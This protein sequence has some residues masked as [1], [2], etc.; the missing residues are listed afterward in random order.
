MRGTRATPP[1]DTWWASLNRMDDNYIGLYMRSAF[2]N[3][4]VLNLA[5]SANHGGRLVIDLVPGGQYYLTMIGRGID[6]PNT[7]DFGD[8]PFRLLHNEPVPLRYATDLP[9]RMAHIWSPPSSRGNRPSPYPAWFAL[10]P[11]DSIHGGVDLRMVDIYG[12]PFSRGL[13]L[14]ITQNALLIAGSTNTA[15]F[16]GHPDPRWGL[17]PVYAGGFKLSI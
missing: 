17:P 16:L 8:R 5:H 4:H 1:P 10:K 14:T 12:Q 2:H 13:I 11:G 7:T 15:A 3:M 9:D 6:Y